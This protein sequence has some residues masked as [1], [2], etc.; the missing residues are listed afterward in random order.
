MKEIQIVMKQIGI[1]LS[2]RKQ[3]QTLVARFC[4]LIYLLAWIGNVHGLP[5]LMIVD[6]SHRASIIEKDGKVHLVLDHT[7]N[8]DEHDIVVGDRGEH[9]HERNLFVGLFTTLTSERDYHPDH[10]IQLFNHLE[11]VIVTTTVVV[12]KIFTPLVITQHLPKFVETVSLKHFLYFY[13]EVCSTLVCLRTTV[14]L[15]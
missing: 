13:P 4:L 5:L 12:T 14:L 15:I 2:E 9:D 10:E 11:R 1:R 7:R 8:R 6:D 3:I